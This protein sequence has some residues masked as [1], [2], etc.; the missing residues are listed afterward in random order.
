MTSQPDYSVLDRPEIL[1]F[2][3]YPR[4]DWGPPP[5]GARDHFVPVE[6]DV[7]ISCRFYPFHQS[8]PSILFFH[9]NGEV[10]TDYDW[11]AP[12]YIKA[13]LNLFVADYRGY[14][15]SGGMP[16][17]SSIMADSHPIFN[18]FR[19]MLKE[20][21][22][23]SRL[24]IMGR[25]LG[26]YSMVEIASHYQ[27]QLKGLIAESGFANISRLLRYLSVPIDP[28][29][30]KALVEAHLEK[31]RSICLPVLIIHGEWDEII[32]PTEATRFYETVGSKEKRLVTVPGA[33]HNDILLLGMELYFSAIKEFIFG[34]G[35]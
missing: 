27:E 4:E 23:D 12:L 8:A 30:F 7:A 29:R 10:V 14:G 24:F 28:Q 16:A 9:G 6:G 21:G 17:V 19:D 18:Y 35:A 11:I 5:P 26:A 22:Y 25:S 1:R 20:G 33:G 32:P 15:A 31:I 3:F 13:G 2:L 34:K